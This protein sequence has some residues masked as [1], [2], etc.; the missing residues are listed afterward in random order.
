MTKD[1]AKTIIEKL[2][3]RYSE[4][5]KAYHDAD[6]NETKTRRDFRINT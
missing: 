4:Q 5:Q 1:Q 6:Y 2:V 3:N